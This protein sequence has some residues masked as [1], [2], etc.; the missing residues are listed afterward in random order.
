MK[1]VSLTIA[2]NSSWCI[3]ATIHHALRYCDA[4]VVVLHASTD[5]TLDILREFDQR[6][7]IAKLEEPEWN[8]MEHRQTSLNIGRQIG[9]THFVILDDDEILTMPV[10]SKMREYTESLPAD[11]CLHLPLLCCWRSLDQY[12]SDPGNP[13]STS[14][15]SVMFADGPGIGWESLDG[16]QHHHTSPYG[17]DMYRWLR[18]DIGGYMHLQ[19]ANWRRLVAKQ[20]WYMCMEL[21]RWGK[22]KADY[23]GTM[24]EDGLATTPVPP[25]WWGEEKAWLRPEQEPWHIAEI[26][27]MVRERGA[28]FFLQHKVNVMPYVQSE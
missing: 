3:R 19:H 14:Y 4:A 26:Q 11:V 2:R 6:V 17:T 5:A 12:R 9:G 13:F 8:E 16:Y 18:H 7:T 21:C 24:R 25:S 22:I 23:W 1:L 10:V 20:T 15:K 27:R 28:E